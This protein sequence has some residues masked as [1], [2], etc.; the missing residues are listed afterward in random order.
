MISKT[1]Q[2]PSSDTK[3]QPAG[4]AILSDS[5]EYSAQELLHEL[6]VHQIELEMQNQTLRQV[7]IALEESRDRYAQLYDFAPVGYLIL[8]REGQI[9][10]INLTGADM[11]GRERNRLLLHRFSHFVSREDRDRWDQ[12]FA[13]ML[14]HNDKL[15][16]ELS[17]K[18]DDASRFYA[19]LDCHRVE[20]NDAPAEIRMTLADITELR[21]AL[22]ALA[23]AEIRESSEKKFMRLFM[24]T[25]VAMG[26]ADA[27]GAVSHYNKKF[28][29]IFGYTVDDIPALDEWWLKACPDEAYRTW[30]QGKWN[31]AV[32]KAAQLGSDIDSAEYN[33]TCKSGAVRIITITGHLSE[34][35]MLAI[36]NDI[37]EHKLAERQL[38]EQIAELR[39][40]QDVT[41]GREERILDLKREVNELLSN[42][43]QPIRY[44][45]AAAGDIPGN[46]P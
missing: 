28:T 42:A 5:Q 19:K 11:L 40:W 4:H 27:A 29:D 43:G 24:V 22:Q 17:L 13:G 38:A 10:A 12:S 26:I 45:S 15:A 6:Q 35:G 37:T 3:V 25:P 16:I 31:E 2:A 39:R 21:Q 44:P 33:V 14:Q 36:F 32:D 46:E 1:K 30:A 34:G 18:R 23:A 9:S 41:Q 8:N 7:Q 20:S